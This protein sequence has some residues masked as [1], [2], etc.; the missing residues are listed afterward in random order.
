MGYVY[1]IEKLLTSCN[2]SILN[3]TILQ[4]ITLK[5]QQEHYDFAIYNKAKPDFTTQKENVEFGVANEINAVATAVSKIMPLYNPELSM[6]E[7]GCK[8]IMHGNSTFMIVSPD[9][10]MRATRVS[11][12]AFLYETKCRS[13]KFQVMPV[14]YKLLKYYVLQVLSEMKAYSCDKLLFTCWSPKS[15]I[16]IEVA[17]SE[18]IWQHAYDEVLLIFDPLDSRRPV[19]VSATAKELRCK[20]VQFTETPC[21]FLGEFRQSCNLSLVVRKSVFG[22]SDQVPH[23]PGCTATEDG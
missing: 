7:E 14:Y 8:G 13:P 2:S 17:F 6:F 5:K 20:T 23:K 4:T 21:K 11:A 10:S 19:K 22:V 15:T 16:A 3:S 12:P 18:Q 1:N 9:R